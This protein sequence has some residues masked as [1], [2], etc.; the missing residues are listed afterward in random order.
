M[1]IAQSYNKTNSQMYRGCRRVYGNLE[2]TWIEANEIQKW[3]NSTNQTVDAD[4]DYLK[5]VNFFDH[6]EEVRETFKVYRKNDA[7]YFRSAEVLS[8][9]EPIF[10]R[11]HF[12]SYVLFMATKCFMTIHCIFIKTRK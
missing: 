10:R 6:L 5:T 7:L 3:R 9:I 12:Q 1:Q 4:V 8:Y 2:I 11:F